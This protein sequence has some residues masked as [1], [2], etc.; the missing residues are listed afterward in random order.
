M[1]VI[2]NPEWRTEE[3]IDTAPQLASATPKISFHGLVRLL[4]EAP[5]LAT[6]Q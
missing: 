4:Q 6:D 1:L 2:K 3:E 5:T